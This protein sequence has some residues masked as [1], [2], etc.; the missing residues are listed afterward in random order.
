[1]TL[2]LCCVG[3]VVAQA[4]KVMSGT[5]TELIGKTADPLVGVNVN[6]VNAQ[7]RSLGGSM[8]NLNGQYNVKIPEGENNLTIVFSYIGMKTQRVKYTGQTN[9]N[10]RME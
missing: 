2:L 3:E 10:I 9:L 8:T 4:Q 1:M 5:V 6:I 7:N